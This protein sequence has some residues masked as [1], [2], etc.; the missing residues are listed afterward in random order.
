M[1]DPASATLSVPP[2]ERPTRA[3]SHPTTELALP[4]G[5]D[6]RWSHTWQD[7]AWAELA[8]DADARTATV[9]QEQRAPRCS[10]PMR[11]AA[12]QRVDRRYGF[13]LGASASGQSPDARKGRTEA[14][15]LA[16]GFAPAWSVVAVVRGRP[17]GALADRP[18]RSSET[19][20]R[21]ARKSRVARTRAGR[22]GWFG[23]LPLGVGGADVLPFC[24][25]ARLWSGASIWRAVRALR[26]P[27]LGVGHLA[28]RMSAL[29]AIERGVSRTRPRTS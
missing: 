11:G 15:R 6:R 16:A 10:L 26:G 21:D 3:V 5:Q 1:S 25:G 28:W 27:V 24:G 14:V 8:D 29:G 17:D 2:R 9:E 12:R 13:A 7:G 23:A 18:K 19:T 22:R 4:N 20:V